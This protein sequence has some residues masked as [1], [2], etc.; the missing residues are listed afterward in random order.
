[1][2]RRVLK[3]ADT[4]TRLIAFNT[5]VR[6]VLEYW[7]PVWDPF[8]TKGTELELDLFLVLKDL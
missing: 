1:M 5:Q 7:C 4:K 3:D 2:L 6:P 8:F